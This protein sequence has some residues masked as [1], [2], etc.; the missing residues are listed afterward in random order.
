[1]SGR[2]R[3]V[4]IYLGVPAA[5]TDATSDDERSVFSACLL[6]QPN[7]VARASTAPA[8]PRP[9]P[10]AAERDSTGTAP[11]V[12]TPT[13]TPTPTRAGRASPVARKVPTGAARPGRRRSARRASDVVTQVGRAVPEPDH[14]P[15]TQVSGE[16]SAR[17]RQACSALRRPVLAQRTICALRPASAEQRGPQTP[18]DSQD[19]M[20]PTPPGCHN[21]GEIT[22]CT[23]IQ[24]L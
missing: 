19:S 9:V 23:Y 3:N 10:A 6:T 16:L 18:P 2:R 12:P 24:C 8:A 15:A 17:R 13:P 14:E 21:N 4:N 1:M 11:Q 7:S 22:K 20:T 5:P